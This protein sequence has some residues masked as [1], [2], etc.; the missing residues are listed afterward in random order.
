VTTQTPL[1]D[2]VQDACSRSHSPERWTDADRPT[3]LR[4]C[5]LMLAAR[6]N[7]SAAKILEAMIERGGPDAIGVE[8]STD[9]P[10]PMT[11]LLPLLET[12]RARERLRGAFTGRQ[13]SGPVARRA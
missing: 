2:A 3:L 11:Q 6:D 1:F 9:G 7:R 12:C 8:C 5:E 10:N 4:V 13:V